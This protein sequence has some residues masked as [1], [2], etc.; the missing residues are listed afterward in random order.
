MEN[1]EER[2]RS[3][4]RRGVFWNENVKQKGKVERNTAFLKN[5][6]K[7]EAGEW[8]KTQP[9]PHRV[10]EIGRQSSCTILDG[11]GGC[12]M[13]VIRVPRPER[14][15]MHSQT[16]RLVLG[17]TVRATETQAVIIQKYLLGSIKSE[18]KRGILPIAP[19]I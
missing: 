11:A 12:G 13:L 2:R 19:V 14:H 17:Q 8:D 9:Q 5:K 3:R 16:R 10:I 4:G 18:R 7:E 1:I 15:E 6:D